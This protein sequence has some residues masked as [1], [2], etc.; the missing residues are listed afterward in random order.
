[1]FNYVSNYKHYN[2]Y[3]NCKL[4]ENVSNYKYKAIKAEIFN[5]NDCNI[6]SC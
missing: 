1:M 4:I 6:R 3:N 2:Y 5:L